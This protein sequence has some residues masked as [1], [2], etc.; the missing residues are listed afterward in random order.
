[1]PDTLT[2]T[3]MTPAH[4]P[5]ALALSQAA[6]WLHRAEDWALLLSLSKG[7]VALERERV[8]ATA[9][10]ATLGPVAAMN[11]IIVDAGMHGRGLGQ[12]VMVRAMEALDPLEW[13]LVATTT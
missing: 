8:V 9:L 3:R 13:R 4:I 2:L 11:M 12:K 7:I 1:M 5:G 10:A 6:D